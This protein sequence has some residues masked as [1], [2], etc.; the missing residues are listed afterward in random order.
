[1]LSTLLGLPPATVSANSRGGGGGGGKVTGG[2]WLNVKTD[3][4]RDE[5]GRK[6]RSERFFGIVK[7][8]L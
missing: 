4:M 3:V 8:Q 2:M 5:K 6:P 7:W 1:M